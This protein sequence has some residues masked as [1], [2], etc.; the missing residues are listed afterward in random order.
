MLKS[1]TP[2]G[3]GAIRIS[4]GGDCATMR[5]CWVRRLSQ[6]SGRRTGCIAMTSRR[7]ST[8]RARPV[9]G[10]EERRLVRNPL[11]VV[12]GGGDG[13]AQAAVLASARGEDLDVVV[14]VGDGVADAQDGFAALNGIDGKRGSSYMPAIR[15]VS[16][17]RRSSRTSVVVPRLPQAEQICGRAAALNLAC[18]CEVFAARLAHGE[19]GTVQ[20]ER[21]ARQA[22]GGAKLHHGLVCDRQ[23][24]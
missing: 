11:K 2:A 24:R 19:D 9:R 12:V 7:W 16:S 21:G 8:L 18:G 23:R 4:L 15:L 6:G 20:T 13:T 14:G 3:W 10:S 22:D 1:V 5:G 17:G